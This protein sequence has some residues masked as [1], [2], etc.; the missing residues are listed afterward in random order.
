MK[1][2]MAPHSGVLVSFGERTLPVVGWC[3]W[4]AED[5]G[6]TITPLA[7]DNGVVVNLAGMDVRFAVVGV[8]SRAWAAVVAQNNAV[9]SGTV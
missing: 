6:A 3:V 5:G 1:I 4:D 7:L 2:E 9:L 8:M